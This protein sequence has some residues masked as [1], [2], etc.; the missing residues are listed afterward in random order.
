MDSLTIIFLA[1]VLFILTLSSVFVYFLKRQWNY[2]VDIAILET[3]TGRIR[4]WWLL[5][6]TLVGAIM[7][8]HIATILLFIFISF[9]ALREYITLTPT[10][11]ADNPT[12]FWVFLCFPLQF[13]M[14]GLDPVWFRSI[15]GIEPYLVYS[16]LIPAYAFL[17]IPAFIAM[18]GD[19]KY[20]LE[21]I[22]K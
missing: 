18:S 2:G 10:R 13:I 8:G 5:F 14:V 20:F 7:F 1:G 17:I 3:F 9:C 6:G 15:F 21:R 4:A 11:P 19:S 16:I 12:L 22:A